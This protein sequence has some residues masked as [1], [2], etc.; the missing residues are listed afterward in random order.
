MDGMTLSIFLISTF[1][2]GLTTG[3]AGFAA[4]LVVSGVWL[5]ILTPVQTAILIASYGII[6]QSYTIWKLRNAFAWRRVLPFIAGSLLG[7]PLGTALL[8][9]VDPD[10][11]R[12]GVGGV[13]V[14]YSTYNLFKPAVT[15]IR[16]GTAVNAVVGVINGLLGGLTGLGGVVITIWVQLCDWPK[17]QQRAVFQPVIFATMSITAMTYAARGLYTVDIGRLMLMGLPALMAGLWLGLK[18]YGRLDDASFRRTILLLLLASGII[19]IAPHLIGPLADA[20]SPA[21]PH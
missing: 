15:P 13:L 19:L 6:N 12:L 10:V 18:L 20:R 8:S 4:G 2:G 11:V 16:S 9:T 7:A 3:I 1:F 21:S 17:D 14:T 5:H